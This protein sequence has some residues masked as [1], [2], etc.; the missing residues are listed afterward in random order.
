MWTVNLERR[1]REWEAL[2]HTKG[3]VAVVVLF[4]HSGSIITWLLQRDQ[5]GAVPVD[6]GTVGERLKRGTSSGTEQED[7]DRDEERPPVRP[8]MPSVVPFMGCQIL[9]CHDWQWLVMMKQSMTGHGCLLR[10]HYDPGQEFYTHCFV[11]SYCHSIE[12]A[13]G[14]HRSKIQGEKGQAIGLRLNSW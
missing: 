12:G 14:S 10:V 4:W 1:R 11:L 13:C 2:T 6:V 7:E 3:H 5:G 8:Q 9:W